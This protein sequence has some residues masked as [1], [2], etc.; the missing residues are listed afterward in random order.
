MILSNLFAR[1]SRFSQEIEFAL[2]LVWLLFFP[3]KE[4]YLFFLVFAF[5]L[6]VF[7]CRR[8]AT[9]RNIGFSPFSLLVVVFN[10]LLVIGSFI[11]GFPMPAVLLTAD[12]ILVS[13]YFLLFYADAASRGRYLWI[14]AYTLTLASL[15]NIIGFFLRPE[16]RQVSLLFKNPILG[17][18][19]SGTALVFVLSF[20]LEKYRHRHLVLFLINL[21]ALIFS[22]SKAAFL[23]AL[24]VSVYLIMLTRKKLLL[25]LPVILVSLALIPNPLRKMVWHTVKADLYATN[26]LEIWNMSWRIFRDHPL[27]GIGPDQFSEVARQYNFAQEKAPARYAKL[28]ESPHSDYLKLVTELGAGG[29]LLVLLFLIVAT[30]HILGPPR[31]APEKPVLAFLLLQMALL[32]FVFNLFFLFVFF[33]LLKF[34][35]ENHRQFR[36]THTPFKVTVIFYLVLLFVTLY[37]F[38]YVSLRL[39]DQSRQN[40]APAGV[41][42]QLRLAEKFNPLNPRI[43]Y[44]RSLLLYNFFRR[45]G[46]QEAWT[47][48]L[49]AVRRARRLNRYFVDAYQLE[50]NLFLATITGDFR[51]P[52]LEQDA[53][54]PLLAAE[55]VDPFNPFLRLQ[56]AIIQYRFNHPGEAEKAARQALNIEP[57]F[58]AVLYFLHQ[59]FG[60]MPVESDFQQRISVITAKSKRLRPKP[61]SY[62]YSLFEVPAT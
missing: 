42:N 41:F 34:S 52:A 11:S 39:V 32:S 25:A 4:D 48:A 36:T 14:L 23:G 56:K 19:A 53:L 55:E 57:D 26:R 38:P 22:G 6:V 28:P 59:L 54:A 47:D 1:I 12:L 15:I 29:L 33:F 60:Y 31:L 24:L 35:F 30:R 50:A 37:L 16:Q 43:P 49:D 5:L 51:D 21:L 61:G 7:S 58:V 20:L 17:G 2:I 3:R 9:I 44:L 27:F 10:L 18:I 45:N 40:K 8:L 62:L 46:N 13:F